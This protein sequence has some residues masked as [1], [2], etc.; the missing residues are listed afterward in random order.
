M[1]SVGALLMFLPVAWTCSPQKAGK[2]HHSVPKTLVAL[3]IPHYRSIQ[4]VICSV[5]W[6]FDNKSVWSED[7][8]SFLKFS[9]IGSHCRLCYGVMLPQ[10]HHC[11]RPR[12]SLRLGDRPAVSGWSLLLWD[13]QPGLLPLHHLRPNTQKPLV[14]RHAVW[15]ETPSRY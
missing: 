8:N 13:S 6:E 10:R 4:G 2:H 15:G 12:V 7:L 1:A 3:Q 11:Q 5:H 14:L 9:L